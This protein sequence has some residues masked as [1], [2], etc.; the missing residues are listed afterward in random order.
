M[1]MLYQLCSATADQQDHKHNRYQ[2]CRDFGHRAIAFLSI[3]SANPSRLVPVC[4]VNSPTQG[5]LIPLAVN[6]T[7]EVL[8]FFFVFFL[9]SD[10]A[11]GVNPTIKLTFHSEDLILN[12]HA[13][14]TF[15]ITADPLFPCQ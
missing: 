12:C 3:F 1:N 8:C 2:I 6:K 9:K 5:V 11:P 14:S 4:S 10:F 7:Q 15:Q 13:R